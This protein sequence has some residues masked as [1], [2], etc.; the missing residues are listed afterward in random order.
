MRFH[1]VFLFDV[2]LLFGNVSQAGRCPCHPRSFG[3]VVIMPSLWFSSAKTNLVA[4]VCVRTHP[5][6]AKCTEY[7]SGVAMF[8]VRPGLFFCFFF[9]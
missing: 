3:A 8:A 1:P 7:A 2:A 5:E 4:S 9:E 6:S